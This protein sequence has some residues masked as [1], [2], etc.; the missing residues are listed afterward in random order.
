MNIDGSFIHN[1]P[2]QETAQVFIHKRM[3][4]FQDVN[5]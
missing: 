2:K 1:N 4:L 5:F 3:D